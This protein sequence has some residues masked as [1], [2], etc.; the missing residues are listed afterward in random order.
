VRVPP[1]AA[2]PWLRDT[3]EW[4]RGVAPSPQTIDGWTGTTSRCAVPTPER[5]PFE[6]SAG[7][8]GL[9]REYHC[10]REHRLLVSVQRACIGFGV[11]NC[12]LAK[13]RRLAP[14]VVHAAK[15][16]PPLRPRDFRFMAEVRAAS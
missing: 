12:E 14:D 11:S 16:Q 9:P 10:R 4:K 8:G 7:D 6:G 1:A 3:H 5:R 15:V 2:C 13:L